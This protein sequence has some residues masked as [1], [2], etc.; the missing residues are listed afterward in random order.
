MFQHMVAFLYT[1]CLRQSD[2]DY[3]IPI[4]QKS[5]CVTFW[6]DI[7]V[8]TFNINKFS[9]ISVA[10]DLLDDIATWNSHSTFLFSSIGLTEL[11]ETPVLTSLS[12]SVFVYFSTCP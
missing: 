9:V 3:Y 2:D 1:S 4:G 11:L 8:I 12:N 5:A 7:C 10:D 6:C